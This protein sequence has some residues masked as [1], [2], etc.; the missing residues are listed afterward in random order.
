VAEPYLLWSVG[1]SSRTLI[2]SFP[3]LMALTLAREGRFDTAEILVA[4]L[5]GQGFAAAFRAAVAEVSPSPAPFK[6]P[7]V[8]P[9][10]DVE[11][12]VRDAAE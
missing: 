5:P 3:S 6:M 12:P 7:A 8:E 1:S 9:L 4:E 10:E 11:L 2:G